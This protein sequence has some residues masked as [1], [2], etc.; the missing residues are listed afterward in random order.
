MTTLAFAPMLAEISDKMP[1]VSVI[2]LISAC[3]AAFAIACC[4]VSR[5]LYLLALPVAGY[6]AF[7][8][9]RELVADSYFR[10]AV[11]MELGR[12]YWLQAVCSSC[13]PLVGLLV[14]SIRD[15]RRGPNQS[16]SGKAAITTR[17]AAGGHRRGLP[18]PS[19]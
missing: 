15:L 19:R 11:I 2:W 4:R 13:L 8:G 17:L 9:Y 6:W 18:E 12:N 3:L 10:D 1:G 16:A 14:W 7:G 5:W